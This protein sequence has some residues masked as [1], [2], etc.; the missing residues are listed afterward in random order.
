MTDPRLTALIDTLLPGDGGDWPSAGALGLGPR[1][2]EMAALAPGGSEALEGVL[3]GLPEGF[4]EAAPEEREAALTALEEADPAR[5]GKV[6]TAGY[7]AYYTTP[8]VRD[9]IERLTGYENRPPQPKGYE[10]PPFDERLLETVRA[11]GPIW[12]AAP[13]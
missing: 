13:E 2:A 11:R 12:R 4:A 7:N 1:M 10:L 5:F 8:A 6:V 9:V 3:A